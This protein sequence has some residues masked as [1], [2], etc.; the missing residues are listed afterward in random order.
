[1]HC[2]VDGSMMAQGI[3]K[4]AIDVSDHFG[5]ARFQPFNLRLLFPVVSTTT[6]QR[7]TT[8]CHQS[9]SSEL[10]TRSCLG[11]VRYTISLPR[12]TSLFP[13]QHLHPARSAA[14]RKTWCIHKLQLNHLLI[15]KTWPPQVESSS[16]RTPLILLQSTM[17]ALNSCG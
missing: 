12:R 15:I 5:A 16:F 3:R 10:S 6:T 14:N 8:R 4:T 13:S 11:M 7:C 9:P 17:K 1:M 2:K